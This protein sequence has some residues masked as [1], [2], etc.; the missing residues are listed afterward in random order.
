MARTLHEI[1]DA[2]G[3]R[4][5]GRRALALLHEEPVG[6]PPS[7]ELFRLAHTLGVRVTGWEVVPRAKARAATFLGSGRLA[8]LAR[9]VGAIPPPG[10][11]DD[12]GGG[13]AASPPP[14]PNYDVVLVDAHLSPRQQVQLEDGLGVTVLDR[15]AVILHIFESRAQT[16]EARLEVELARLRFDL[17]RVRQTGA[18][19]DRRGGG[20]RGERGHTNVQLEKMRIRDRIA[21]L[22]RE[23]ASLQ[24]QDDAR[25]TRRAEVWTAALVGYTNAGKSTLMRSLTGADVLAE[26]KLFATL[27]TTVR[28]IHPAATPAILVC[29]TVG[30][31]RDLPHELVASF[32]STLDQAHTASLRLLVVDASDTEWRAQLACVRETIDESDPAWLWE[33]EETPPDAAP[34]RVRST[35][36]ALAPDRLSDGTHETVVYDERWLD[37]DP[38]AEMPTLPRPRRKR[39][40]AP[41]PVEIPPVDERLVFNKCDQLDDATRLALEEEFP[42]ALFVSALDPGSVRDLRSVIVAIRDDS[43]AEAELDVPWSRGG[44]MSTIRSEA[45]VVDEAHHEHGTRLRVRGNADD[46]ARW[47]AELA[48][49]YH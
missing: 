35:D 2:P 29:D 49:R 22:T 37:D 13:R 46:L 40:R 34:L 39:R 15:T 16:R 33:T 43:L 48:A 1:S 7:C 11:D 21:T 10:E 47:S 30:F 4:L 18:G 38:D 14:E 28:R 20:G 12:E 26:D 6:T 9:R 8:D 25:R 31:I 23:L 41:E 45:H 42:D 27:G 17:P 36:A 24:Q 5:D 19:D 32:H 44:L 3:A